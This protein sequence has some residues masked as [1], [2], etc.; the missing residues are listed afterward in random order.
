MSQER[1]H[2][3]IGGFTLVEVLV[4]LSLGLVVVGLVAQVLLAESGNALQL[5]RWLRER[6]LAQR[7]LALIADE[8]QQAQKIS[9]SVSTGDT[10]GCGL[11]GRQ[12]RLHLELPVGTITYSVE[13][14]PSAIWRGAALMRCGP[15]YGLNGALNAGTRESSVLVDAVAGN[16]LT[17][18]VL[19]DGILLLQLER[20]FSNGN[21][22]I[23]QTRVE[24][25]VNI[26]VIPQT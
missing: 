13:N 11:S 24:K 17:I 16:T 26:S 5:G 25:L 10:K 9:H 19:A 18:Q 6:L 22:L 15:A 4:A 1:N 7:A 3:R 23:N 21:K 12:V 14:N 8:V 2:Q 20:G